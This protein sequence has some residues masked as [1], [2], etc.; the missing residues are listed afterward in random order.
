MKSLNEELE[1]IKSLMFINEQC[2]S[3]IPQCEIDLENLGYKV[4][5]SSELK[6]TC[7]SNTTIK[8]VEER[9]EGLSSIITSNSLI[10][11]AGESTKDCFVLV[12]SVR[13]VKGSPKFHFSFYADDQLVITMRLNSHNN[14]KKLV[15]SGKYACSGYLKFSKLKYKG[16]Y[17][18]GKTTMEN[19]PVLN[20]SGST[21]NVTAVDAAAM[22][23]EA[24]VLKMRDVFTWWLSAVLSIN[25]NIRANELIASD[26]TSILT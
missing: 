25:K 4:F 6:T 1:R 17:K 12:K 21:I 8:C 5:S 22:G 9:L 15:Y 26:V 11:S 10:S 14:L 2:G 18:S 19:E 3:D 20:N 13:K 16:V 7:E 24:G 23:I